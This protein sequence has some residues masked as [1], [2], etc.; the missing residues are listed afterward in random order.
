MSV[1]HRNIFFSFSGK[2]TAIA[3]A[4]ANGAVTAATGSQRVGIAVSLVFLLSGRLLLLRVKTS[5]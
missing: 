2:I 4:L 1:R 3:A 5:R